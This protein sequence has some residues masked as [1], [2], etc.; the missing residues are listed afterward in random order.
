METSKKIGRYEILEEQGH[1][2]MGTVYRA[3]DPAMNRVVALKTISAVGFPLESEFRE[4]FYREARAAAVLTH[5]GIVP[6]F[7]MGEDEGVPYLVMEFVAGRTLADAAKDGE[8]WTLDRICEIGQDLAGALGYAHQRGV[9][10]RDIKPPNILLTSLEAYGVERPKITDFGLAKLAGQITVT[11]ESLGTPAFMSPEQVVGA[12]VD[13]RADLFSL[14]VVIYW[15]VTGKQPFPGESVTAVSYKVLHTDAVPPR[16]LNPA[17]PAKLQNLILKCMAK[18]PAERYQTGEELARD[19]GELRKQGLAATES[20]AT[21]GPAGHGGPP[22]GKR[23]NWLALAAVIVVLAVAGI[24]YSSRSREKPAVRAA[25]PPAAAISSAPPAAISSAPVPAAAGTSV[26]QASESKEVVSA[27]K[28][29]P[30]PPPDDTAEAT[31]AAAAPVVADVDVAPK[32]PS[33]KA[34]PRTSAASPVT[35]APATAA[36]SAEELAPLDFDPKTLNPKENARLKIDATQMPAGLDFTVEMNGKLYFQKT[37]AVSRDRGVQLFVPPGVH[38]LRVTAK[39][40]AVEKTSNI[41]STEFKARKQKT[42]KIELRVQ[43]RPSE[44]GVPQGLYPSTQI[45]ATLK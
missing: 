7:D 32:K 13:G 20:E 17:L 31:A 8:H 35:A 42:L 5:P 19:L 23:V 36:G 9:V 24:W 14:G 38:E 15:M 16:E 2:G 26:T 34:Q 44:A 29:A 33:V 4:R 12:A 21:I 3:M 11:G 43:G 30:Q 37:D 22:P 39:S 28:P 40:G 18:N 6:V 25:A 1:G 10:H 41:V 45:V 27:A